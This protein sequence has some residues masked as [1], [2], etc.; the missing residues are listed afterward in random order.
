MGH[1][2]NEPSY[3]HDA[4]IRIDRGINKKRKEHNSHVG[5]SATAGLIL[6]H[7]LHTYYSNCV[8]FVSSNS[9]IFHNNFLSFLLVY[10]SYMTILEDTK[11]AQKESICCPYPHI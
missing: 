2:F 5:C 10:A 9:I 11:I 3:Y 8:Y 1:Y 7:H 4:P 6:A